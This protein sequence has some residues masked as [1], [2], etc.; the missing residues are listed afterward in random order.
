M[1][2]RHFEF[3][4]ILV[5]TRIFV[6]VDGSGLSMYGS[7]RQWPCWV[8][9]VEPSTGN[10]IGDGEVNFRSRTVVDNKH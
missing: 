3:S 5:K 10:S 9:A 6:D 4:N 7:E 2:A 1:A 8:L